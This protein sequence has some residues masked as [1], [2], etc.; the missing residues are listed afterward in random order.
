MSMTTLFSPITLRG[1][2]LANRIMIAPMCQY[3]A[4]NGSATASVEGPPQYWRSQP[5]H[6]KA[7]FGSAAI[8]GAR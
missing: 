7:L 4:E 2:K 6:L 8:S 1:L 3:S 5:S